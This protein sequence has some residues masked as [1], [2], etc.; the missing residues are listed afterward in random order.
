MVDVEAAGVDADF[1]EEL[2]ARSLWCPKSKCCCTL[3]GWFRRVSRRERPLAPPRVP[4]T[5]KPHPYVY[6]THI[7][8][9]PIQNIKI[10]K[11]KT[12][13]VSLHRHTC[14]HSATGVRSSAGGWGGGSASVAACGISTVPG[15]I[16]LHPPPRPSGQPSRSNGPPLAPGCECGA[17]AGVNVGVFFLSMGNKLN[18]LFFVCVNFRCEKFSS[19]M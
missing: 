15:G 4:A 12:I 10:S 8:R 7:G 19:G 17:A 5:L 3:K 11:K 16:R 9:F 6:G 2:S 1:E 18:T 13:R 14:S